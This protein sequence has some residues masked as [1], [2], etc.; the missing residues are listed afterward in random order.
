VRLIV[1][2]FALA[3]S[4]AAAKSPLEEAF[5][6]EQ[7]GKLK[8]ARNLYHAAAEEFRASAAVQWL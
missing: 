4:A 8:E 7:Q 6:L 3:A 2:V 5:A 1:L